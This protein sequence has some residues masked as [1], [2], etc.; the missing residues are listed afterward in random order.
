M[1]TKICSLDAVSS[2]MRLKDVVAPIT[3][4]LHE[5]ASGILTG[6]KAMATLRQAVVELHLAEEVV[7]KI[8]AAIALAEIKLA[9]GESGRP[10]REFAP[11]WGPAKAE[12]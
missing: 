8:R 10:K 11:T 1:G 4:G 2:P 6:E 3:Q 12:P 5:V 7:E 9:Y